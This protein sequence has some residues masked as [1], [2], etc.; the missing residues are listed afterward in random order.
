[1]GPAIKDAQLCVHALYLVDEDEHKVMAATCSLRGAEASSCENLLDEYIDTEPDKDEC[2]SFELQQDNEVTRKYRITFPFN[3][4][5]TTYHRAIIVDW[6]TTL[7]AHMK[8]DT[9]GLHM[10]V[11]LMDHYPWPR[12]A[13]M[14][15]YVVTALAALMVGERIS[16][17][18]S[19]DESDNMRY[20]LVAYSENRYSADQI[21]EMGNCLLN[22]FWCDLP[23]PTPHTFLK[24]CMQASSDLA[25]IF[26]IERA[27]ALCLYCFDLGLLNCK[28]VQYSASL[29]CSAV[30]L[31]LRRLIKCSCICTKEE[32]ND[33]CSTCEFHNLCE[34]TVELKQAME[35][36]W[37][38]ELYYVSDIYARILKEAKCFN[39]NSKSKI[40]SGCAP[41]FEV[42]YDSD[43]FVKFVEQAICFGLSYCITVPPNEGAQ[44]EIVS[45]RTG[46]ADCRRHFLDE[47]N[48]LRGFSDWRL[49]SDTRRDTEL[50]KAYG[51]NLPSGSGI[52]A[53]LRATIFDWMTALGELFQI[54]SQGLHM[55]AWFV[56]HTQWSEEPNLRIYI[57]RVLAA[58]M[59][60]DIATVSRTEDEWN[61]MRHD[62]IVFAEHNFSLDQVIAEEYAILAMFPRPLPY[63][64]PHNF[65]LP[66]MM[67]SDD[68]NLPP[69]FNWGIGLCLYCFDLG[70]LC[71]QLVQYS[72]QFK[73]AAV[74]LLFRRIVRSFCRCSA[75]ELNNPCN[76][77]E[78]H[79]VSEMTQL[80]H[81]QAQETDINLLRSVSDIYAGLLRGV[82]DFFVRATRSGYENAPP[83]LEGTWDS[84]D[85]FESTAC[86]TNSII[87]VIQIHCTI[88]AV[89]KKIRDRRF[90]AQGSPDNDGQSE[91]GYPVQLN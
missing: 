58:L 53:S 30:V 84:G 17:T 87:A 29:K 23:L 52:T 60:G 44:A 40:T 70:L 82:Q 21:M 83:R 12:G 65:L 10:A 66:F 56:N 31:L 25:K 49:E 37:N 67:I 47:Y 89:N 76:Q 26:D 11:W 71:D 54:R 90:V 78:Y 20:D 28:L 9:K 45:R 39:N 86:A 51:C 22:I 91:G 3:G 2:P 7:Q 19:E 61:C 81:L 46:N 16:S 73:C 80:L 27:V 42:G 36:E 13:K 69:E 35:Q 15:N 34:W 77:C 43:C 72:A 59:M 55:A 5:I 33:P 1:M 41:A 50:T 18:R 63:P 74:V 64:T 4:L 32:V 75:E 85:A 38:E 8:M 88:F 79:R 14:G 48:N 62:L 57:L 6:M 68:E 24:R